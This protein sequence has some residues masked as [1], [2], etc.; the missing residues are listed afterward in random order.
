MAAEV[1]ALADAGPVDLV[2]VFRRSDALDQVVEDAI[3]TG[4][5]AIW[6]QPGVT[7][8]TATDRARSAGLQ[9]VA[10]RCISVEH[11][12]LRR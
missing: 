7:N 5:P 10:N 2:N 6:T 4:A 8:P 9:V 12:R 1:G 3:G 11:S